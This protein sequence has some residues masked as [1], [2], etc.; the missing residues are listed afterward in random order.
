MTVISEILNTTSNKSFF[1]ST[2]LSMH[3]Q[4]NSYLNNKQNS[5]QTDSIHSQMMMQGS[6]HSTFPGKMP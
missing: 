1:H 4:A 3:Q 5:A 6:Q 2:A